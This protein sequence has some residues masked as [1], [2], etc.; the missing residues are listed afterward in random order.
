M[1]KNKEYIFFD[2]MDTIIQFPDMNTKKNWLRKNFPKEGFSNDPY[3]VQGFAYAALAYDLKI[4]PSELRDYLL[5]EHVNSFD[6]LLQKLKIRYNKNFINEE[7][8]NFT[9]SYIEF[10]MGNWNWVEGAQKTLDYYKNKK[11]YLVTNI[12]Y[13]YNK[14]IYENGIKH[15]FDEVFLSNEISRRKPDLTMMNNIMKKV[16]AKPKDS[17]FIGDNWRSD[18]VGSLN[19]GMDSIFIN[20]KNSS[21]GNYLLEFGLKGFLEM[22][23]EGKLAIRND[24]QNLLEEN[25]P[26][27]TFKNKYNISKNEIYKD[28]K[29]IIKPIT[30]KNVMN[31]NNISEII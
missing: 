30:I 10:L 27:K 5:V 6:E 4:D 28:S 13:P 2:C 14:I 23:S 17:V 9:L 19:V 16:G 20:N 12:M 15:Y 18:I 31:V 25:L 7:V 29:N 22:D 3:L 21:I 24:Y 1:I 26:R 8:V 11:L